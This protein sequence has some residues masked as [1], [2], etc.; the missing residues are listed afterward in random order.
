M[1]ASVQKLRYN[2]VGDRPPQEV[3]MQESCVFS[4]RSNVVGL[5]HGSTTEVRQPKFGLGRTD[6]D[7]GQGFY[8]TA[9]YEKAV[10]WAKAMGREQDAVVS[11]YVIDLAELNVL[12]LN[13]CGTLAWIAEIAAHRPISSELAK[14][15]LP[16]FVQM[17]KVDTSAADVIIGYRADDSYTD[18]VG[19]F[20]EMR[21]RSYECGAQGCHSCRFCIFI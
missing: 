2:E 20:C 11:E 15:F 13:G 4:R 5:Y 12:N 3:G 14:D 21:F 9:I 18:V 1:L 8:T 19:A 16:D 17:Y 6:N 10:A 7:Y